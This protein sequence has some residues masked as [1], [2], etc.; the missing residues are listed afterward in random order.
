MRI[1]RSTALH[2]LPF[3]VAVMG[4]AHT[5]SP[6][7][8]SKP[9]F[10][11][12][13]NLLDSVIRP[14]SEMILEI[15][16]T[17]ISDKDIHYGVDGQ[18]LWTMFRIDVRDSSGSPVSMTPA[19]RTAARGFGVVSGIIS[20]PIK[21]G[22]SICPQL[23]LNRVFNLS[24]PGQYQVEVRKYDTIT[25]LLVTSKPL[26]VTV[27]PE[28]PAHKRTRH[29]FSIAITMPFDSVKAGWLIP[30]SIA[31]RNISNHDL[32]LAV[33]DGRNQD[34]TIHTPDEF[35]SGIGVTGSHGMPAPLTMTGHDYRDRIDIADG[36]FILEPIHPGEVLQEIRCIG[37]LID[38]TKPGRYTIQVVLT[39]PTNN[40]LVKSNLTTV[41]VTSGAQERQNSLPVHPPFIVSIR[42]DQSLTAKREFPLLICQTNISDRN[43]V[44]DNASYAY[45]FRVLDSHGIKVPPTDLGRK[46]LDYWTPYRRQ[47]RPPA[48]SIAWK[49]APG[50]SL[51]GIEDL[52]PGWDLSEPGTY[53]VQIIRY[54]YPDAAPGQGLD[55]LPTVKSNILRF[56]VSP[57]VSKPR[58]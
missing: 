16:M 26:T 11:I 14:P 29:A 32:S 7:Q 56:A 51:C 54:D 52:A 42:L 31:V 53:S 5:L 50:Q 4:Y 57:S 49:I 15:C 36:A 45:E 58:S 10:S 6:S 21:P 27:P 17:N 41:T 3:L 8:A 34:A 40:Q 23:I 37:D 44:L 48:P 12:T 35:G 24:R 1:F 43:I 46:A 28:A 39:D 33:W 25:G 22:Q 30:V 55:E 13:T 18:P 38:V 2:S 20:V 9:S 19:G 47:H